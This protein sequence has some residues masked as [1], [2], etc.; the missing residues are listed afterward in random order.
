MKVSI[1]FDQAEQVSPST[2]SIYKRLAN[3]GLAVAALIIAVNIWF[4]SAG[5]DTEDLQA[6]VNQLG[7]SL[8]AQG[9]GLAGLTMS[10]QQTDAVSGQQ[11]LIQLA[12]DPHVRAASIHDARG[13]ELN[14][15]GER[16]AVTKLFASQENADSLV[17]VQEILHQGSLQGYIKLILDRSR[18]LEHQSGLT[19]YYAQQSQVLMLLAFAIGVLLTRG[20]YKLRY[21]LLRQPE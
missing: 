4:F 1:S 9:A 7:R 19:Q 17:Y 20:F 11:I 2:Y 3:L 16:I 8:T 10:S 18:V 5:Q 21:P 12:Q 15:A 6:Q 13:R 14:Q